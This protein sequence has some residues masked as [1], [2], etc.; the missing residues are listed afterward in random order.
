MTIGLFNRLKFLIKVCIYGLIVREYN[1]TSMNMLI[2]NFLSKNS[3]GVVK[4]T[5]ISAAS[6]NVVYLAALSGI[7]YFIYEHLLYGRM[8]YVCQ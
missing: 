3:Y 4:S 5:L 1:M 7:I 2:C 8:I 6:C